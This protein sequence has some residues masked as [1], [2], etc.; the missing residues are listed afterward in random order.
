MFRMSCRTSRDES[1]VL[2]EIYLAPI[3]TTAGTFRGMGE[4]S[5]NR[6]LLYWQPD[7][8]C[9]PLFLQLKAWLLPQQNSHIAS[10]AAYLVYSGHKGVKN[11]IRWLLSGFEVSDIRGTNRT[12]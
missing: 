8:V 11:I 5:A 3:S 4:R 6:T 9:G 2:A 1:T 12:V 10:S 7:L